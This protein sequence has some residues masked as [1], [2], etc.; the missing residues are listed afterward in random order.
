MPRARR[1]PMLGAAALASTL[2]CVAL[3]RG[4]AMA[5]HPSQ[6]SN[7][8]ARKSAASSAPAPP[9]PFP[10]TEAIRANNIGLVLMD[11]RQFDQALAKFQTACILDPASDVGCLNTGISFLNMS[12]YDDARQ[13]LEKSV[14]RD[15]QSPRAWFNLALLERATGHPNAAFDDFQ[16]VVAL[17]PDD[18]ITHYFLGFLDA[19]AGHLD[20]ASA[21]FRRAI[22][23]DPFQAS[24][25]YG[26]AEIEHD[27]GDAAG[28]RA[29][30]ERFSHI[31]G[32][33]LGQP[34]AFV[35]G[36]QGKYSLAGEIPGPPPGPAPPAIPVHFVDI[37]AQLGLP[38]M[39]FT[40]RVAA[41]SGGK[42]KS[43]AAPSAPVETLANFLGSGACVF[44][45][46]GDGKPDIF[47]VNADGKGNAALLRNM[48]HG[49][50]ADVTKA[51]KLQFLGEGT[52]CA[53]GDYDNDGHPDLV[54][55]SGDGITLF[56]NE[57]DGTFKDVTDAAG[58]RTIGLALGVTFVDYDH[59]GDLDLYVTRFN[60]FPL[61]NPS[62]PFTFPGDA[63]P[64]GNILWRNLG[65]GAFS[66]Y[67]SQTALAGNDASVGAIASD[68]NMDGTIDLVVTGWAN[69]PQVFLN[70]REG[71]FR[72]A[73]PW[74]GAGPR[75][76]AGAVS[77][78]FN[79]DGRMD[80]AF[81]SWASPALSVWRNAGG[82]GLS[83][84]PLSF[85]RVDLPD[86][87]WMRAWGIAAFDYDNDG[88][89]DI[90]AVGETFAGKGQ[91][92]LLRNEGIG[93]DGKLHFRDVTRET[94]LDKIVL[95]NP[96][97]VIAFD[98]EGDGSPDLL[99][100][101]NGLPPVLLKNVGANE[102]NWLQLALTGDTDNRDGLGTQVEI[103]SGAQKQILEV[104][105]ASGYLGQSPAEIFTGLGPEE[106]AADVLRLRWPTGVH[107]NVIR[108]PGNQ[109][110]TITEE[111]K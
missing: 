107:Q 28:S 101:Q 92:V 71:P 93:S 61:D 69:S 57:G 40:P 50:F 58:V 90:V 70:A 13:I 33:G 19:Q 38:R 60:D 98:P 109:P 55:S 63:M 51:A 34:I 24:A 22:E 94:G 31:T 103:L 96:R 105:G 39:L 108:V 10:Y 104:P 88:W 54:V 14:Q 12:R 2:V 59:D 44:D 83:N 16:K 5:R 74:A 47:L 67:T 48:G 3:A 77:A 35:Y 68:L 8:A 106:D 80:L 81:T 49:R 82:S 111:A 89:T 1:W 79:R 7:P 15:P 30:F 72:S 102:N 87:G 66:D 4:Q 76:T 17:D 85:E 84:G 25:E 56:H 97:S 86:P 53:V 36:G 43:A 29:H 20:K 75:R 73:N 41:R 6:E 32:Q 110:A 18:A 11:R 65:G 100:T 37:S 45:Y 62:Q 95:H 64:P 21:E 42:T 91:I 46:D 52:G 99:I 27:S 26:L 9:K 23:I 78:D